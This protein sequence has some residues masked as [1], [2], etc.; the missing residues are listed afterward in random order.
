MA[1]ITY[2]LGAGASAQAIPIVK[3]MPDEIERV[4]KMFINK[5]NLIV[6]ESKEVIGSYVQDN[7]IIGIEETQ[8]VT[9]ELKAIVEDLEW[10]HEQS[11]LHSSVDTAAKKFFILGD[12]ARLN[13]LKRSLAI[14]FLLLQSPNFMNRSGQGLDKRYDKF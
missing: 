8:P 2:L 3:A 11:L 4:I 10:L 5:N 12:S 6:N 1:R 13:R 9:A 14:F 7:A